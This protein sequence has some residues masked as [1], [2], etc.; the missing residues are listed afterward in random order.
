MPGLIGLISVIL[1]IFCLNCL[2]V[3]TFNSFAL[4]VWRFSTSAQI[5]QE[6]VFFSGKNYTAGKNFKRLLVETVVTTLKTV[7]QPNKPS[8]RTDSAM[9][10][11][12]IEA[13]HCFNHQVSLFR[14]VWGWDWQKTPLSGSL[15]SGRTFS[16]FLDFWRAIY[17]PQDLRDK[18]QAGDQFQRCRSGLDFPTNQLL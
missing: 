3:S 14:Q 13:V 2:N 11:L 10:H 16:W 15:H 5:M 17:I 18:D 9:Q 6:N 8:F 1:V 4:G 12:M 7:Y